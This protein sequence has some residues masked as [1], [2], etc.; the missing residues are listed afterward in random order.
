MERDTSPCAVMRALS[1]HR[2]TR[3]SPRLPAVPGRRGS[4]ASG[5][6]EQARETRERLSLRAAGTAEVSERQLTSFSEC[7]GGCQRS[8]TGHTDGILDM[9]VRCAS[10][11]AALRPQV[12][13]PA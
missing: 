9:A 5:T 10:E 13:R 3:L 11:P 4:F 7:A 1:S 2:S 12:S 6:S 8:W